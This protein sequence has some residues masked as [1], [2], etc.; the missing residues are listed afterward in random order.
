MRRYILFIVIIC[1][2]TVFDAQSQENVRIWSLTDCL[3]YA[4]EQNIQVK[5]SRVSLESTGE[6]L[7]LSRAQMFPSLSAGVSQSVVNYPSSGDNTFS[8]S[9][10]ISAGLTLFD[11][12]RRTNT[13]KQN[14]LRLNM[15]ELA[16][17]QSENDIRIALVQAYM[18]V[19]YAT[20]SVR[21]NENTVEVSKLQLERA[22]E[23]LSAGSIS[24]V[25]VAQIESQ[26]SSDKYRLVASQAS[27]SNYKLQLKQLLE[28][29]VAEEIEILAPELTQEM[30]MTLLPD[31]QTI[32][33]T[34]LTVMPEVRSSLLNTEIANLEIQK[35]QAGYLPT[36]SLSADLGTGH[37]SGIAGASFGTQ[38]SDRF[39]ESVRLSLNIP[40][41]SNRQNKTAVSKARLSAVSSELDYLNTEKQLLR[42]VE[43]LYIDATSSQNQYLAAVE[44]VKYAEESYGLIEEQFFLGMKNTLELL[45]ARNNMLNAQQEMLQ[46]KFMSVMNMQLLNIYQKEGVS[47]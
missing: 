23:L 35:A 33:Q 34:A 11:G 22:A 47:L 21:I 42:V 18:Q 31:K 4:L 24:R 46:T 13:I 44:Q 12:G 32:Y 17:E 7:Q 6:D 25:D 1:R 2:L 14:E 37:A 8:G 10:G 27:L 45:T 26:H 30:I 5:K 36:L 3:N 28:L 19:L 39:N 40:I 20:E 41:Y 43:G 15:S 16:V 38:M 29:D 9:Y